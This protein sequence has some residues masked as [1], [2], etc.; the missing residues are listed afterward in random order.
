MLNLAHQSKIKFI[1]VDFTIRN[2]KNLPKR[3]TLIIITKTFMGIT[4]ATVIIIVSFKITIEIKIIIIIPT[5]SVY[6]SLFNYYYL[7]N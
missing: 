5:F 7:S 4:T 1:I 6:L 2:L 3:V